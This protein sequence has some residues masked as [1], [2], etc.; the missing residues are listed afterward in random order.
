MD[1]NQNFTLLSV[2]VDIL[3]SHCTSLKLKHNK[4]TLRITA[5]LDSGQ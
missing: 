3:S 2:V 4:K 1:Y 5:T